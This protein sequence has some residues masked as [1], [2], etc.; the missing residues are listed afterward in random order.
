MKSLWPSLA[1][2][3][4]LIATKV[5]ASNDTYDYIVVGSGP[6]GGTL[7]AN[8]AKAGQSVLLLEAG[9]DQGENPDEL[10]AGWALLAD[11][12]PLMRWDF[13]VKYHSNETLNDE[14]KHLTWRTTDGQFYV[15]LDPPAG[16]VK[17][18]VYYPRAGTLGGCST[19]NAL[20]AA[21][22]SN[23]D[24]EYIANLTGDQSWTPENMRQHFI[25]LE[26]DHVVPVGTPGHG[27][28]G[29]LDISVN[30]AEFLQNQSNAVEVFKA[31]AS[32]IGENPAN[33]F[34]LLTNGTDLNNDDP[35]R[36]QQL[37]WFGLPSH[38]DLLGRR[39][40]ARNAV[41]DVLN[42]TNAGGS[43]KYPLTLSVHSLATKV[44]FDTS[45]D[46]PRAIGVEYLLGESM[47]SADP[48]YNA[49]NSGI[50]K[51]A[52]ARKEVIVSGGSFNSPQL[53]KLSGIGPKSELQNL[54]IA[55]I[56]DLPGV[57]SNLED[58][59]EMGV[60]AS[61][62][63]N[64]T[65]IGPVC[66]FGAPGD[67][68][69][70]LWYEGKGPYTQT[71][72]GALM[73]KTSH[74]ARDERDLFVFP[75]PGGVFRGYWPQQ[76]VNVVPSD[77]PSSFDFSMVKMHG[78]GRLGTVEL[79]SNNPRDTPLINFRFFE[80]P[81]ADAD[82]EALSEGVDFGRK[83][84]ASMAANGSDLA[85]FTEIS[86][87]TGTTECDVKSYIISQ[88]W[89]HHA[90][91]SCSIG[92]DGDPMAVLDSKFRVRGTKGLRVVDASAHPRTPGGFP[93]LPTFMLG[94]KASDAIL[95]DAESW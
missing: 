60:A 39:V 17:L 78:N 21:L 47:Y 49:S 2:L 25:Q 83:V 29:F 56:V 76:T 15:G 5:I 7:A 34:D 59:Y 57:G 82:L 89:S 46:I 81:G 24:W 68:C 8:L 70:P 54:S 87:C 16:A 55:V 23:S 38:R 77:P 44:L 94:M 11:G 65:S 14:Y 32:V 45:Q 48:R 67:P 51:Q 36:D 19:H 50:T 12:D 80:G 92:A 63:K 26:N 35:N 42:A 85:P 79:A 61:A 1:L 58:N 20:I 43:K 75:L 64:F 93:V 31:T 6:G 27:F 3:F 84:F 9:D 30:T 66:T 73:L 90:T 62:S 33:I 4:V 74:A 53:L 40:S 69:L 22:P 88:A 86:P 10:I 52:F 72:L 13:F 37:G 41:F 91:S 71:G 95:E 28:S 18:G